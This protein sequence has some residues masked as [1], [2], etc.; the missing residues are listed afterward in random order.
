MVIPLKILL[1]DSSL[2]D[3]EQLVEQV[4]KL[5][6]AGHSITVDDSF[7]QYDFV[8]GPNCWLLRPEVAGL[9]NLAVTNARK[10]AQADEGRKRENQEWLVKERTAKASKKPAK[11]AGKVNS[12]SAKV[13]EPVAVEQHTIPSGQQL[14]FTT[15]LEADSFGAGE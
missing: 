4:A 10:I 8:A 3:N 13:K 5:E 15:D 1:T 6:K 14:D 7:K 12:R 2:L 9:F 11:R